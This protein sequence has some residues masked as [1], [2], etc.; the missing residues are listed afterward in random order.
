VARQPSLESAANPEEESADPVHGKHHLE[1]E[2]G[3]SEIAK[4]D[5]QA[6]AEPQADTVAALVACGEQL[7]DANREFCEDIASACFVGN[8][9]ELTAGTYLH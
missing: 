4:S 9:L 6:L 3:E 1:V 8:P 2:L 7:C 5:D